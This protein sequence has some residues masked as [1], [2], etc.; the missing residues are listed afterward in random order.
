[1]SR[2]YALL[3]IGFP[4][5]T[6]IGM[7][8]KT[9][10]PLDVA[11]GREG[12]I[13]VLCSWNYTFKPIKILS[14]EDEDLGDLGAVVKGGANYPPAE[15]ELLWPCQ[16]AVDRDENLYISDEGRHCIAVC[17][18]DGENLG[19]WG[20][21]GDGDG[22]LNRPSGIAFDPEDNIYVADTLNHRVQKF[23]KDGKFLMQ[24]GQLGTGDGELNMP[25]GTVIDE[26]GDVYVA[27]WR[28]DRIQKFSAE[29]D[30]ILKFGRSGSGDGEFNRPAGIAVDQD[31]D[32]YVADSGNGRVQLFDQE[33]R[34]VQQFTGDAT[35]TKSTVNYLMLHSRVLR[36]HAM[37]DQDQLKKFSPPMSVR[38]DGQGR[39]FVPDEEFYR[40]QVYQKQ[41]PP[42]E[43]HQLAPPMRSPSLMG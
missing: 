31:G 37:A 19:M 12:R 18:K 20:E 5:L 30:F 29:G 13:Y 9:P 35:L 38:V 8:R 14:L 21:Y 25:W 15:D 4:Y 22:Q 33:G 7:R 28:N 36:L 42:L 1:M 24:F 10:S 23:T 32:I 41:A 26:L 2:P 34:Y 17:S 40:V 16:V 11:F 6:S 39:M 27:D 43:P 3:R